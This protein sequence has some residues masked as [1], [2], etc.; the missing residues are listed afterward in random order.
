MY[1]YRCFQLR[2]GLARPSSFILRRLPLCLPR[3][4]WRDYD[5]SFWYFA[6]S[7]D[8]RFGENFGAGIGYKYTDI[9]IEHDSG[10]GD[11]EEYNMEFHGGTAYIS[12]SF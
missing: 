7:L 2:A 3:G 12:Y 9:D 5:G 4:P 10:G 1:I 8:Y 11:F 6:P